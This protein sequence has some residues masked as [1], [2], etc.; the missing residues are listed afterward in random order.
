MIIF[1]HDYYSSL[2]HSYVYIGFAAT[3]TSLS[4]NT[5]RARYINRIF[6][7]V[8]YSACG[9]PRLHFILLFKKNP[10]EWYVRLDLYRI[11]TSLVKYKE[12]INA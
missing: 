9:S 1:F 2:I 7:F 11:S 3:P 12:Y 10:Y 8:V 5:S 6:M 4:L